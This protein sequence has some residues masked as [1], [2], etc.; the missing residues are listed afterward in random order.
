MVTIKK[1]WNSGAIRIP[2][3]FLDKAT[4]S[5]GD[6][7]DITSPTRGVIM[8]KKHKKST[9]KELLSDIGNNKGEK[10]DWNK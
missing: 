3:E 5:I 4:L 10:Y 7:L 9:I 2:K 8:L 6:N 1:W